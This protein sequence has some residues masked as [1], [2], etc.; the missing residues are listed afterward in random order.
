VTPAR[1]RRGRREGTYGFRLSILF[2]VPGLEE[3]KKKKREKGDQPN[4]TAIFRESAL[5]RQEKRRRKKRGGEL[6]ARLFCLRG[7]AEFLR[8]CSPVNR[9][10]RREK[11]EEE[12]KIENAP[13]PIRL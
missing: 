10:E 7:G 3:E 8:P 9:G 12:A 13:E 2:R 5:H 6:R 11:K 4:I 1:G